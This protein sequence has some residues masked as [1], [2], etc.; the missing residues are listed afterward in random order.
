[1]VVLAIVGAGGV[2]TG[3]NP[4]YTSTEIAHHIKTSKTRFLISEPEIL[5]PALVAAKENDI[6]AENI[7]VFDPIGQQIPPG[8]RSW[9]ELLNHGE[10]DW[11]RFNDIDTA[12]RTVAARLFSSGTTGLPKGTNITH[13]NLNAQH[14]LTSKSN[15]RPYPVSLR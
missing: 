9:T 8:Q 13:Y 15:P 14:E 1:M 3:T 4:A 10:Q 7:W 6:P 11:V 2:F 12:K 5:K